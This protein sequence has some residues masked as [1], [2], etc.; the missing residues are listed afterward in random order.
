MTDLPA[1]T[2]TF[3]LTDIESS[4]RH[5]EDA[6]IEMRSALS[7]HDTA[8][9]GIVARHGGSIIKH[10]GDGCWAAFDTAPAAAETAID[11]Q[12]ELQAQPDNIRKRLKVRIGLHTGNVNPTDGDYFGTVPNRMARVADLANG[13]Q[14]VCSSATAGLLADFDL[15]SEGLHKL[16]DIGVDEVFILGADGVESDPRP[17]RRPVLPSNLPR[18][19]TSF[20]GR[21]DDVTRTVAHL[22]QDHAVVT[23]LGPGGVGKTRLS[24]EAGA[25]L[26]ETND[27]TVVFCDLANVAEAEDVAATIADAIGAR[28]QPGM[29]LI[30][31]IKD[32][33]L[34][35]EF[36]LI[37]DN[38][39][40]VARVVGELV[41]RLSDAEHVDIL[42]TSRAALRVE[43]EQLVDVEPL[44]PDAAGLEL[45]V[46]RARE[47][48]PSFELTTDNRAAVLDITQR[49]DGIPLAIELAA[50]RIRLMTPFELA[51]G[52]DNR[53]S[54]LTSGARRGRHETLHETVH[55][56]YQ[57]LSPAEAAVFIRMSVFAGGA[58][59]AAIAQVCADG[60]LVASEQVPD[61]V[62][63]LVEQSMVVSTVREGHRRFRLLETMRGFGD[64]ELRDSDELDAYRRRHA[65]YY[66][67]VAHEQHD[68][69]FTSA[70]PDVWRIVDWEWSN[71]RIAL[72]ALETEQD[73]ERAAD[74]VINLADYGAHAMRFELFSW[75]EELLVTPEI[76]SSTRYTDLCGVAALGAYFTVSG[77][78]TDLA[79]AGLAVDP[80]DPHGWCRTALAAVF[81][82]NVHTLEASGDLTAAW[83]AT[84]P[85]AIGSQIWSE[86]LRTYHLSLHGLP[87][88]AAVHAMATARIA[89]ET[90]SITTHAMAAWSQGLVLTFKDVNAAIQVW[91][92]ALEGPRS[93]PR[94]HLLEQLLVG[95]ILNFTVEHE[96]LPV[97]LDHCRGALQSAIDSHYYV[98]T[99]HLFGVTAIALCR[100]GDPETGARLVGAMIGNGHLPRRNATRALEKALGDE[101]EVQKSIGAVMG[102][103][104]AS[105]VAL[106]AL[107][108][109]IT[110]AVD[111]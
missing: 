52:L 82:N 9:A 25:L 54:L 89:N 27:K 16:R 46:S 84:R 28:Q 93:M 110:G 42:A 43:G 90:S 79:E 76:Q 30:D 39:E 31:S 63:S 99:S 68:R 66:Y 7:I 36:L 47:H 49:L 44:A 92:E 26:S 22:E 5:W 71:L 106:E 65:D 69:L 13:D 67:S 101:A 29:D 18:T 77:R 32:Y 20:L 83:L 87:D 94:D 91:T 45:F 78:V 57:L 23:L 17:L 14:I 59:L 108:A 10:L 12:R 96:P 62:L 109:A 48:D 35:R 81:L 58:S 73:Y 97:A 111:A 95:L 37:L 24:I 50:A 8:V 56:S 72:D 75:A 3:L 21:D 103:T 11:L 105:H 38:C 70:E 40:Q 6:P 86:A 85:E 15:R 53:F 61:L 34:D 88:E 104:K 33:V 107:D 51:A 1:G 2:V 102:I 80:N 98:G 19:H 74:L 64:Q 41:T 55:W 100:A 4:S 60:A